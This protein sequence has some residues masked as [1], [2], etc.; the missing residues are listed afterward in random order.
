MDEYVNKI[1]DYTSDFPKEEMFGVIS[2]LRRA[3]L[4]VILNYV[5]GYARYGEKE[6]RRFLKISYGSLKESK[7]ISGF[8]HKR[9]YLSAERHEELK[10]KEE[11]IGRMLWST[12]SRIGNK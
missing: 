1:Y 3:T 7:Y 11:E 8:S 9:G 4:S 5:E 10:D 12:L 2:Q 6:Y